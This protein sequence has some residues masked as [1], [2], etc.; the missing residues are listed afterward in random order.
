MRRDYRKTQ[1]HCLR[2]YNQA[3]PGV[4]V[5]ASGKVGVLSVSG[6]YGAAQRIRFRTIVLML[7][8]R[9]HAKDV[10]WQSGRSASYRP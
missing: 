7:L 10:L 9:G 1:V 4:P 2:M 8:V 6:G 5:A 3:C